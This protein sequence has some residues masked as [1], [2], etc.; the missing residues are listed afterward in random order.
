MFYPLKSTQHKKIKR[1]DSLSR[2]I[3]RLNTVQYL[4]SF[5]LNHEAAKFFY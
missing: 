3:Q 4:L 1:L 5:T 2:I